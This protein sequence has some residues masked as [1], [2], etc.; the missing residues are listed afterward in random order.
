MMVFAEQTDELA[1]IPSPADELP[2]DDPDGE[3]PADHSAEDDTL[4]DEGDVVVSIGDE[5]P[6]ADEEDDAPSLVNKLRKLNREKESELRELRKKVATPAPAPTPA[7]PAEAAVKPT[8]AGCDYD[9]DDYDAKLLKWQ[10]DQAH[11]RAAK[12]KREDDERAA[13]EAWQAKLAAHGTAKSALKVPDFDEAE[14]AAADILNV[15][16]QSI[17]VSGADNS[18]LVIY[19]LG[20]NPAKAKEFAAIKDP[21]KF[22][23]AVAKL[24]TQL[25]ITPRRAPPPPETRVRGGAPVVPGSSDANLERLR[26]DAAKTGDMTKL[27]AYKRKQREK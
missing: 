15:T 24:E 16:Q 20:K 12:Q 26:T 22:A 14:A 2:E 18:A 23:F 9:E 27:L 3:A 4:G 6:P 7:Q 5:V 21:V 13:N 19:A 25:K 8:L 11:A 17:I 1:E 10:E